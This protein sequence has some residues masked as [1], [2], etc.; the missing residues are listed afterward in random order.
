MFFLVAFASEE[1]L[2]DV[3]PPEG[4]RPVELEPVDPDG[5]A[6]AW[7]EAPDCLVGEEEWVPLLGLLRAATGSHCLNSIS[8]DDPAVLCELPMFGWP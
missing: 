8:L 4:V 6:A 5:A 7:K 2:V 1:V 3:G